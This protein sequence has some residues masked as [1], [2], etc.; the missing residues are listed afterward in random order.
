MP[1]EFVDTITQ[2]LTRLYRSQRIKPNASVIKVN[3]GSGLRVAH[4]WI[5][6]DGSLSALVSKLPVPAPKISYRLSSVKQWN[7]QDEYIHILRNHT[8]VFHNL[9]YGIP[10][11]DN[12]V[13]YL[14]SSHML[15]HLFREDAER[16]LGEAFRVLKRGGR[17]RICVPDLEYA[18]S[19]YQQG[20]KEQALGFFFM[21][22]KA[23][24]L[25]R[26]LYMYDFELIESLL[27]KA[28]FTQVDRCAYQDG[29]VPDIAL[30]DNRPEQTLFVEASK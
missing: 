10:L 29:Q 3:L 16:L 15:E 20:E 25:G 12:S 30:L 23:G 19:L 6:I 21:T 14:Y 27:K 17:I 28:G 4:G 18:I 11:P 8:F 22:S 5:N 24:Y 26:H 7:S 2:L 9:S 13:D 1:R